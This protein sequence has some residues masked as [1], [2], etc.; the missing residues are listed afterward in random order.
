MPFRVSVKTVQGPLARKIREISGEDPNMCFQCGLCAGS[1]PMTGEME[2]YTRRV[3]H[4]L[5]LGLADTV[6]A[7]KMAHLCAS[8]HTC[9]VRC[10]RGI[11][12][13]RVVETLRLLTLRAGENYVAPE[14]V[15]KE[16]VKEMP[17]AALVAGFR[18]FTG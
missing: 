7:R 15:P 12:I 6:I 17:Q 16:R 11:D 3:M 10:P 9:E 2:I 8:C 18:K 5:Q 14:D 1:C 13:P 4:M